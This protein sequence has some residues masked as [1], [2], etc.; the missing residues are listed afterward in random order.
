MPPG[1]SERISAERLS[2][3][4]RRAEPRAPCA[5]LRPASAS[6]PRVS[7]GTPSVGRPVPG[8]PLRA[9]PWELG[10][11]TV[12]RRGSV[13]GT[14]RRTK[15]SSGLPVPKSSA[16]GSPRPRPPVPLTPISTSLGLQPDY[17]FPFP[18]LLH[19]PP[20]PP[21]FFLSRS[22]F[23]SPLADLGTII[24]PIASVR[25]LPSPSPSEIAR[26]A[27]PTRPPEDCANPPARQDLS[28]IS[29]HLSLPVLHRLALSA[30]RV[31]PRRPKSSPARA[32]GRKRVGVGIGPPPDRRDLLSLSHARPAASVSPS[33]PSQVSHARS[34]RLRPLSH[35][36]SVRLPAQG[37]ASASA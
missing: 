11:Q 19:A 31:A 5:V 9:W 18:F 25:V 32:A 35:A 16:R 26:P 1:R 21:P 2:R 30:Q 10:A 20:F 34:A 6:A 33:A 13:P 27:R 8:R 12:S 24:G 37:S 15:P 14:R 23:C 29:D 3:P 17:S 22:P 7:R 28:V 4:P 36:P